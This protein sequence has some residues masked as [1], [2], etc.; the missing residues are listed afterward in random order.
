MAQIVARHLSLLHSMTIPFVSAPVDC[1][2]I[3]SSVGGGNPVIYDKVSFFKVQII[4]MSKHSPLVLKNVLL[5]L[6]PEADQ[7]SHRLKDCIIS[8]SMP[9]LCR[10][11]SNSLAKYTV[12]ENCVPLW[13]Y[14]AKQ[15]K[16]GN[17]QS[18]E[19]REKIVKKVCAGNWCFPV[20]TMLDMWR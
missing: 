5:L 2:Q 3:R 6:P 11:S 18:W 13:T 7:W 15:E 14:S 9:H 16:H 8:L 1:L 4:G 20:H 10:N 17:C 19:F 12:Q